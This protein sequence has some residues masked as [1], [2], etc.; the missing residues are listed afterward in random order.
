[1]TDLN[2]GWLLQCLDTARA[3]ADAAA[4]VHLEA[5]GTV[6]A[7]AAR[8]KDTADFVS[9]VDE[10]AQEAA[11]AI[12]RGRHPDHLILA[13]EDEAPPALPDDDTPLWVVDP[14]DGTTNFLHGHP[15]HVAS[16]AL[17]VAGRSVVGAVTCGPT[18]ERWWAARGLGAFKSE[19]VG[20]GSA[21]AAAGSGAGGDAAA[22]S[23]ARGD[24]A[25]GGDVA[26]GSGAGGDVAARSGETLRG[27]PR[28]LRTSSPGSMRRALI[29]TGFPFRNLERLEYYLAEFRRV[30]EGTA[31]ARRGGAAALDLC[32]VAEGRFDG[33]WEQSLSPWDYAAGVILIEEAGGSVSRVEGGDITLDPGSVLAGCSAA[34]MEELRALLAG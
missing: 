4:R 24:V 9:H 5:A 22:G 23:G 25:V 31:G 7:D 27:M 12:I 28:R 11:L 1:M 33:F 16:V 17:T 19:R 32:Y 2:E 14:L 34:F 18:G 6:H 13:E 21:A 8:A 26:A 15:M 20:G 29:G 3:A 30:V 10:A